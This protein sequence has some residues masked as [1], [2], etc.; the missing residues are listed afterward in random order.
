MAT[1]F[2]VFRQN[3]QFVKVKFRN[4][5]YVSPPLCASPNGGDLRTCDLMCRIK[6]AFSYLLIWVTR[7]LKGIR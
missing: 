5:K 4:K 2:G 7:T 6:G 3:F 1:G